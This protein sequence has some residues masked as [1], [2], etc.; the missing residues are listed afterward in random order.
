MDKKLF[1][2]NLNSLKNENLKNKLKNLKVNKFRVS[3]GSDPLDINF[4]S[5]DKITKS[6]LYEHS[7]VQLNEKLNLYNDKYFL[8]PVFYFFGFGNGILYKAL[9]QNKNHQ[10]IVVF[11]CELEFIYLSFH[12]VDFSKELNDDA[13]IILDIKELNELDFQILCS[14][15]P[16]F[17]FLRVYFLDIHCDYYE[18]F[19]NEILQTNFN[20]QLYIKQSILS[21]GNDSKDALVGI[22]NY[23]CNLYDMISNFTYDELISKRKRAYDNAIIVSTGPSLI[24]QLPLLK[25]YQNKASIFCADSAYPILAKEGIK[26]DYVLSLERIIE[27][28]EF[29]NNDFGDFDKDILFLLTSVVH[30]N[31]IEYLKKNNRKFILIQRLLNFDLYFNSKKFG[32]ISGCPSVANMAYYIS[33]YLKYKNIIFIGQDLAYAKDGSSH[34]KEYH[35][36]QYD[37]HNPENINYNLKTIAYGGNGKIYTTDTWN[38]FRIELQKKI[39]Y[40]KTQLNIT[41]YNATEG[42]ARI[43]GTIEKPFKEL[44]EK[45]LEKNSVKHF[46]QL[47]QINNKKKIEL[48]LKSFY[49]I[50][51]AIKICQETIIKANFIS[52]KIHFLINDENNFTDLIQQIDEF[53]IYIEKIQVIKDLISPLNTQFELNLAKIYILHPKTTEDAY[54]KQ[55]LWI[56]EHVEWILL[57]ENHVKILQKLLETNFIRF[58]NILIEK[59]MQNYI[60]KIKNKTKI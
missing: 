9:L 4:I 12:F 34:P 29:F 44:C 43:E 54:N 21:Y 19:H 31:T 37:T 27:T 46:Q 56:K 60:Y 55:L 2:K 3:I 14:S 33:M 52:N 28:S 1:N 49:K 40:A 20:I 7:L 16:C 51:Q 41:T 8:Y 17:N 18:R 50:N 48:L 32:F 36:G 35:Y 11:E 47:N 5:N 30:P 13:L 26:P 25:R 38:I 15:S 45:L 58:E 22:E 24:K 23:F 57:I 6:K 39:S 42:G 10:K 59:N 53:K